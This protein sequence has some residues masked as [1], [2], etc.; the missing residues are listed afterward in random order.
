[1]KKINIQENGIYLQFC[2]DDNDNLLLYNFSTNEIDLTS[3][4]KGNV[5][6]FSTIEVQLSGAVNTRNKHIGH[7]C[8][9]IPK[10]IDHIDTSNDKGRLIV[11]TLNTS[12]L[13]IKQYYQFYNNAKT[14]SCYAEVKNIS[15]NNLGLE[16]VSSFCYGGFIDNGLASA[17]D[18]LEIYIPH[19]SWCEELN[20]RKQS[21][22]EAGFNLKK[23]PEST[24][25]IR[26]FNRGC[27]STKEYLPMGILSNKIKNEHYFWQIEANG[28]WEWELGDK[29]H[30]LYLRL[31][32]PTDQ[33]H[34]W[35]KK[36]LT[37]EVYKS[38]TVAI[39]VTSNGFDSAIAEM[40]KYRRL[41]I[42]N[43]RL[44]NNLPV[45][46]N[47]YMDCL[48]AKPTVENEIPII[49][50]AAELGAEI[51]CMDAGWYSLGEWWPL[52]GEW[53]IC[54][55]RFNGGINLIFE[56]IKRCGM[57]A[58]IWLEPEVMGVNCPLVPEFEDCFFKYRGENII[59]E[60]RYQLDFRK[61]K[62]INHLNKVIDNLIEKLGVCY[63]KFDY[64][65]D[66]IYGTELDA[67]SCGDG[68][69]KCNEAYIQW[70]DSLYER[71]P[72]LIIENCASGGMRMDYASLKHFAIQS[73]SDATHYNE[74]AH[75][76][77]MAPTAVIPEQTG[78][79]VVTA[80]KNSVSEN[81]I[82]AI[83]G[84]LN[85]MYLSG[86][87]DLL[88]ENDFASLKESVEIYKKIRNDLIDSTPIFPCGICNSESDWM[89][90]GRV[91]SD[92]SA[93]YLSIVNLNDDNSKKEIKLDK[94][95]NI[96]YKADVLY[97]KISGSICLQDNSLI[98][99][100]SKKSA[101]LIKLT[102][103]L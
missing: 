4:F 37:N 77:V 98:I 55:E 86:R 44:D 32:G 1:M 96:E 80:N 92:E 29:N 7:K 36:L 81:S 10:Y 45:I 2:V 30:Q 75:M 9:D 91:T 54:E 20:W 59:C 84:M 17:I 11:F 64:N 24:K 56:K 62:V 65:I 50:K 58:G 52:V 53:K 28:S 12:L 85:R 22:R 76:S 41:I 6:E 49:E 25:H 78:I 61:E 34:S 66:P 26:I 89:V 101:V 95:E 13:E 19:N 71:H 42:D 93:I 68:L 46:F 15:S 14:I 43:G 74:F 8:P 33:E 47:D 79:W 60:G 90:G 5:N 40:T 103:V 88:R 94:F 57:R 72:G 70:I 31:S 35:Y 87:I 3:D 69:I 16:Y 102:K 73:V 48:W 27:W 21:L 83:N 38:V 18:D 39:T 67:D 23:L 99:D 51:Y 63:F 97:P 100:V 82:A